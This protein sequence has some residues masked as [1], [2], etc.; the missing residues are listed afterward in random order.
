[1]TMETSM[2][3]SP[4]YIP[5]ALCFWVKKKKEKS[6]PQMC[7][8]TWLANLAVSNCRHV[9][10]LEGNMNYIN[11]MRVSSSSWGNDYVGFSWWF[12][13]WFMMV[14]MTWF[15]MIHGGFQLGKSPFLSLDG[16]NFMGKCPSKIRMMN[17][18]TPMTLETPI[19]NPQS[20]DSV[21][22]YPQSMWKISSPCFVRWNMVTSP[23]SLHF[24]RLPKWKRLLAENGFFLPWGSS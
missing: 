13:W 15:I 8:Q 16:K 20:M 9:G 2:F 4:S 1:M 18:G 19:W 12:S 7:H 24:V 3:I 6:Y 10:L 21:T 14:K 5:F 23:W 11:H 22:W 17:R